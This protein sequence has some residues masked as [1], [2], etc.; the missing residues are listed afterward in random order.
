MLDYLRCLIPS[1]TTLLC[2]L[3]AVVPRCDAQQSG[4][5]YSVVGRVVDSTANPI[6]NADVGIGPLRAAVKTDA[7]GRF[8]LLEIPAGHYLVEIR[9]IGYGPVNV[10]I[11]IPRDTSLTSV[12]L[13]AGAVELQTVVTRTVGLFDKPARLAYT[14]KYDEF[15]ERRK[16]SAA[17]GR[18]YT[19]DDIDRMD[20]ITLGDILRRVPH[21]MVGE[22]DGHLVFRFPRCDMSGTLIE[23]NGAP[24]SPSLGGNS[25]AMIA[26][27]SL[28][29]VPTG[30]SGPLDIIQDI[31]PSMIEGIEVYSSP[32]SHPAQA[33]G[34]ACAAI[35][36]WTQ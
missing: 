31:P 21:M 4:R 33:V 19:L 8:R 12:A 22:V 9:K 3:L 26:T 32:S 7:Y 23:W 18:F 17:G 13:A 20:V 6:P 30:G 15:Y 36:I 35:F 24:L 16:S 2:G 5:T 10:G 11:E 25:W 34:N 27:H 28:P 1:S 29:T 14:S